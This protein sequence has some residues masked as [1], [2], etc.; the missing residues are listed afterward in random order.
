M[1]YTSAPV[2][3]MAK[4]EGFEPSLQGFGDPRATVTLRRFL[5]ESRGI[6]PQ[7]TRAVRIAFEARPDPVQI[8]LRILVYLYHCR[9]FLVLSFQDLTQ[10]PREIL[11]S[12]QESGSFAVVL[13]LGRHLTP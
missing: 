9:F 5:A 1:F 13:G 6:E 8:A 11:T 12:H 3:S 4:A 7:T 2:V 10:N